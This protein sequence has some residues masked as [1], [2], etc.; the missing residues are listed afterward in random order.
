MFTSALPNLL[1]Y[2]PG[3]AYELA[4][5]LADGLRRMYA[6]GEDVFYYLTL[7]NENY[8][9]PPMPA[10][11]EDGIIKGLYRFKPG[12]ERGKYRAHLFGS[13][14]L[15]REALRAQQILA[16]KF[17]VS[18]DVWSVTS[19]KQLR[20]GALNAARWNRLHPLDPPRK[21][22]LEQTLEEETGVFVAVSDHIKMVPDQI[23]PWVRGGLTTLGTDGFGRSDT[24]ERLRRFFEVDAECTAIATLFALAEKG[25]LER[26]VVQK[27]IKVLDVD[28]EKVYPH[29]YGH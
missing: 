24:R 19:Y 2:D 3:F 10:G 29:I 14:P 26:S 17:G 23:A 1:T 9:M 15:L 20:N 18:A 25:L 4:V 22:Y 5:I 12:P 13:G 11:V 27:A 21:S 7:Y 28:P 16:D 6:R 8:L